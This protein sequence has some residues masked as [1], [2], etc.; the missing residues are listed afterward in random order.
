M[1]FEEVDDY[2][3]GGKCVRFWLVKG[4][5]RRRGGEGRGVIPFCGL[6]RRLRC[7]FWLRRG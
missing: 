7:L 1:P 3:C 2:F 4:G 5:V 6:G